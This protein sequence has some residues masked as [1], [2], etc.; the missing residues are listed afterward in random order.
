MFSIVNREVESRLIPEICPRRPQSFEGLEIT[1]SDRDFSREVESRLNQCVLSTDCPKVVELVFQ[2]TQYTQLEH[3]ESEA[4]WFVSAGCP[5]VEELVFQRAQ[6]TV[7][8]RCS[9]L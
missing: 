6:H 5:K 2:R 8:T 7:L 1:D 4:P 3:F 9:M